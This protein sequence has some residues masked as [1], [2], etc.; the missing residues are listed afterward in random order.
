MNEEFDSW[1][2]NFKSS[3]Q[4]EEEEK[5]NFTKSDFE[6]ESARPSSEQVMQPYNNNVPVDKKNKSGVLKIFIASC[7][8]AIIGGVSTAVAMIL[9]LTILSPVVFEN[10]KLG[11]EPAQKIEITDK[12]SN[13]IAAVAK[14]SGPSVV[15]VNVTST[16]NDGWFGPQQ[17][18]GSGS[19]I[20]IRG[21]GYIMTNN[22]VIDSSIGQNGLQTP[23][24]KIEVALSNG[25]KY[26]AKVVGH[27]AR[28]DLAVLKI[29]ANNL[30]AIEFA[31]S[32]KVQVGNQVVAI[33]NPGGMELQGSVTVGYVSGLNR[34][35]NGEGS[36]IKLI[37]TDASI[38]PGNSGG[39]LVN[40]EGKL[41]GVNSS[42]IAATEFEG[43]G[44]A[45]P[46]NNAKQ[47]SDALIQD[48]YIK[49]YPNIGISISQEYTQDFASAN[50][51]PEGVGV[52][53]VTFGSAAQQ[54]GIK[55]GDVITELNGVRVKNPKE[56]DD[57]KN[58]HKPGDVMNV[59][60]YRQEK[61]ITLS[62][63]L[64]ETKG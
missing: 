44:F 56:L 22:H 52:D 25:K 3:P 24:S 36:Q 46:S 39:A 2:E 61:Y 63:T 14:K 16:T 42:K 10:G 37:Q 47:I 26:T 62:I 30:P 59:K 7:I 27:D 12:T 23:G 55:P 35:I 60:I 28:T 4:I 45:I 1:K 21:D 53:S 48:K 40:L 41:V 18:Q 54:A 17:T 9:F 20:I 49:G 64:G 43:I 5:I 32:S 50:N 34:A 11:N 31:D 58:K 51:M 29:E 6:G 57:E 8:G 13:V 19:G 33:G 38:N 15:G